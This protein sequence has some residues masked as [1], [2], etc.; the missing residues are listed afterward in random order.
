MMDEGTITETVTMYHVEAL[1]DGRWREVGLLASLESARLM[2]GWTGP[3]RISAA[4][5]RIFEV[6]T[7]TTRTLRAIEHAKV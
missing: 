3:Q 4:P 2:R 6:T 7:E 1:Q 5:T